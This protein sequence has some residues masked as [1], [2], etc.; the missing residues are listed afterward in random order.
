[1]LAWFSFATAI[2][3]ISKNKAPLLALSFEPVNGF[4]LDTIV[5][6]FLANEIGKN[7]GAFPASV[8]EV[9]RQ[10]A[11]K[12]FVKE[13]TAKAAVAMLALSNTS[14]EGR[15]DLMKRAYALTRRETIV[16]GWMIADSGKNDDVNALLH[17]YDVTMRA[18]SA[19]R[20]V[21]LR[22]LVALMPNDRFLE[23]MAKTLQGN[24][25]WSDQFWNAILRNK[26]A[27][28]NAVSLRGR[29]K[30]P[31]LSIA[32]NYDEKL[33]DALTKDKFFNESL[34]FYQSLK[35]GG[36]ATKG[37]IASDFSN[38]PKYPP[39]DWK[40]TATGEYGAVIAD[41]RMQYSA[42]PNS[43]GL[44]AR[45]LIRMTPGNYKLD[46]A[47]DNPPQQ[48]GL[49]FVKLRCAEKGFGNIVLLNMALKSA[50]L[51]ERFS[52]SN[53]QCAFYWVELTGVA[54]QAGLDVAFKKLAIID[55]SFQN[56]DLAGLGLK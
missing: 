51:I 27:L 14:V 26:D 19:V 45:R 33:I 42:I 4:A 6:S 50:T 25:Q 17:H 13:P 41:D 34:A 20:D 53:A 36:M 3:G 23:P 37:I 29:L 15:R 55:T 5:R 2:S 11:I 30:G 22:Q 46:V 9:N 16:T 24:P 35:Q 28:R 48:G 10:M 7:A 47:L 38:G 31:A 54:E 44:F 52:V 18:N 40:L 21:M 43:G 1:M 39:Y 49:L 8:S 56:S 12:A 32:K